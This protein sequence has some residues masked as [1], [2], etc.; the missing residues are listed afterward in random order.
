MVCTVINTRHGT[1]RTLL[2]A[3]KSGKI[4]NSPPDKM[5]FTANYKLV[6]AGSKMSIIPTQKTFQFGGRA[7]A[8]SSRKILVPITLGPNQLQAEVYI[9]ETEIPFLL[10]GGLLRENKTEISVNE[11]RMTINNHKVDLILLA[12]G[13]IALK[14]DVNLHKTLPKKICF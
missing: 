14:W 5:S 4:R 2:T 13:H 1:K 8:N 7:V 12:S 3:I 9:V 11:N 6:Q 10:G